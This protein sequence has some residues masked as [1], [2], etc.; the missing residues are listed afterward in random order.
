MC[1]M[2]LEMSDFED[3]CG[4]ESN[5]GE[6]L[7]EGCSQDDDVRVQD[8]S[9]QVC[10]EVAVSEGGGSVTVMDGMESTMTDQQAG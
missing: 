5:C 3:E 10:P 6:N 4:D 9:L 8:K 7:L 1:D 2:G